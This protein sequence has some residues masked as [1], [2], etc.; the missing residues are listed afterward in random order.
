MGNQVGFRLIFGTLGILTTVARLYYARKGSQSTQRVSRTREE[1]FRLAF[2]SPL[3]ALGWIAGV[4]YVIA[5]QR[6]SWAALPIPVWSRWGGAALGAVGPPLFLW[7]HHAL[8]KNWS[9]ALVTKEEQT[10]VAHGPYRWVRHPMYSAVFLQSLSFFLLSANW[11]VGLGGLVTS[12]LCVA[13]VDEEEVLMTEEF[14]D[15]YRS[16]M[17]RTGR[18]LPRL[19]LQTHVPTAPTELE[20]RAS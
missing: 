19:R 12:L 15:E 4:I 20:S 17:Q 10:L 2:G 14:G 6:V 11:I 8:G 5:P 16:Y 9:I 3:M 7:T 18:F 13:R 1:G